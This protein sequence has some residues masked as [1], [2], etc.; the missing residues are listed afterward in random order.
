MHNGLGVTKFEI[1]WRMR[2]IVQRVSKSNF[3]RLHKTAV[4]YECTCAVHVPIYSNPQNVPSN[5][6]RCIY[7]IA[8]STLR[9][10]YSC[11]FHTVFRSAMIQKV[12]N[13][14][15]QTICENEAAVIC[16]LVVVT[17]A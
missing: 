1:H 4:K 17:C 2:N 6:T 7:T 14:H 11:H 13:I 9:E 8:D 3:A 16:A 15:G 5:Q 10:L 12:I